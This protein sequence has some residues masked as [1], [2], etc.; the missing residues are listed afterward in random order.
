VQTSASKQY[1]IKREMLKGRPQ[2]QQITVVKHT[3][4]A[5]TTPVNEPHPDMLSRTDIKQDSLSVIAAIPL[6]KK[7]RVIHINELGPSLEE[8]N[9]VARSMSTR[10]VS[11]KTLNQ[12]LFRGLTGS[13]NASDDILKIKLSPSN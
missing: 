1:V 4:I 12:H 7:L 3:L 13:R 9:D 6:K 5:E 2:S 10:A 8:E 11:P